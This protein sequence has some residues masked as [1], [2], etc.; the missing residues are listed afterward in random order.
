M[1]NFQQRDNSGA[2]F[3]NENKTNERGPD[4]SG[5]CMIDGKEYF[6]DSWLK[7][8]DSGR[9]WMSFSFKPKLKQ[10]AQRP[11]DERY[12]AGSRQPSAPARSGFDDMDSDIPF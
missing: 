2:L 8:S 10:A 9:K 7:T 1:S 3:K 11:K 4:Y 6:F 12:Q 5:T